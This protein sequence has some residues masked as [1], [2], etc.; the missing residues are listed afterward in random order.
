MMKNCMES[1]IKSIALD[2]DKKIL[3]AV[4]SVIIPYTLVVFVCLKSRDFHQKT[5]SG[6][7]M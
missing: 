1:E 5:V 7:E 6:P 3:V 2:N 4:N